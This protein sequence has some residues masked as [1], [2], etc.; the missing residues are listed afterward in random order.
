MLCFSN[1][2]FDGDTDQHLR[3]SAVIAYLFMSIGNSRCF[4]GLYIMFFADK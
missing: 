1:W 3:S 2:F 4:W